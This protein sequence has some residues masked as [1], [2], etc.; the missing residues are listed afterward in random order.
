MI[1]RWPLCVKYSLQLKILDIVDMTWSPMCT[2]DHNLL[3][4]YN[5]KIQ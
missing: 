3:L 1:H 4:E 5:H 2:F